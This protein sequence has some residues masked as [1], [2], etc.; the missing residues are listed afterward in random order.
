MRPGMRLKYYL[1]KYTIDMLGEL[2]LEG[3]LKMGAYFCTQT[4]VFDGLIS[5]FLASTVFFFSGEM[6]FVGVLDFFSG[7]LE[8]LFFADM[9]NNVNCLGS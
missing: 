8:T 2:F 7:V 3:F 6:F 9:S 1:I 4:G 5:F